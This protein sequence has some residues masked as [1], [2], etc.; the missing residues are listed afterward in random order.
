MQSAPS[1]SSSHVV[2]SFAFT[3]IGQSDTIAYDFVALPEVQLLV[4]SGAAPGAAGEEGQPTGKRSRRGHGE[5]P[6]E[7]EQSCVRSKADQLAIMGY[8]RTGERPEWPGMA[9]V[10]RL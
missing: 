1:Y 4:P 10:V 7:A 8:L 6:A 5:R 9:A 2:G 3:A